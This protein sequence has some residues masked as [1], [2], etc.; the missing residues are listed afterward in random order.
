M[1]TKFFRTSPSPGSCKLCSD[2]QAT[3]ILDFDSPREESVTLIAASQPPPN[4]RDHKLPKMLGKH[5]VFGSLSSCSFLSTPLGRETY[6]PVSKKLAC[7]GVDHPHHTLCHTLSQLWDLSQSLQEESLT[8]I[9]CCNRTTHSN[10]TRGHL[11]WHQRFSAHTQ[12]GSNTILK[13]ML[14]NSA[15]VH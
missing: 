6:F 14:K 7:C 4:P 5:A 2:S 1:P 15:S 11:R 13:L 10:P 3:P 12:P 8:L 9:S